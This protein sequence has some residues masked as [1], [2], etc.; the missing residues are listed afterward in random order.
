MSKRIV[1][2]GGHFTPGLA[3]VEELKKRG[4]EI[5]WIG[6]KKAVEGKRFISLEAAIL[7]NLDI[8]FYPIVAAKLHRRFSLSHAL[9][10]WKLP[11]SFLQSLYLLLKIKPIAVLSFGSYV[12]VPVAWTAWMLG[13]PVV[14]HEQT[15][16]SGLANR[17]VSRVASKIAIS[18]PQAAGSFPI[19]KVVVT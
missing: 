19:D 17:L 7:P 9:N 12:S 14:I 6:E 8:P 3:V 4:W 18:F 10:L 15:A 1:I 2:T 13:I 5:Y 11:V 16:V